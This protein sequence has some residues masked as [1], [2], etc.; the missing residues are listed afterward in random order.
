MKSPLEGCQDS[1]GWCRAVILAVLALPLMALAVLVVRAFLVPLLAGALI[2]M[3]LLALFVP[4]RY[5]A[6]VSEE[7]HFHK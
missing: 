5:R 6:W 4:P 1:V 2:I 3:A 7:W